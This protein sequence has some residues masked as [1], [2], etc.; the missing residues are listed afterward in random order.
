M[1]AGW[2]WQI[3]H[4]HWINRGYVYSSRFLND[5][6]AQREFLGKNPQVTTTPRVVK[7]RTGRYAR[8]W[9]GNVVGIGNAVGFVEPLEATALQV[10]C[11]ES[12]T[13]ADTLGDSL[14]VPPPSLVAL[15]NQFNSRVWDDIRDFLAVHFKFNTRL[16]TPFWQAC[17]ADTKLHG[18]EA[19]V[20]FYQENGPSA[21]SGQ[22]L[23]PSNSFGVHGYLSLLVGQGVPH[24]KRY[25][26]TAKE[27]EIWG[28][29]QRAWNAEAQRALNVKQCLAA[30][31]SSDWKWQ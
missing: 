30:V 19:M 22:L 2:C 24:A 31:R 17:R 20:Q 16:D 3:E 1:D 7:F 11:V 13:L 5:D 12:M 14:G 8:N 15:Y 23:H 21:L 29:R 28:A 10:I 18:A 27:L 6:L 9:V 25:S 26:A 4:E